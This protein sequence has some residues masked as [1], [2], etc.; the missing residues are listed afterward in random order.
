MEGA[1]YAS[2]GWP[3]AKSVID[4]HAAH[5][6]IGCLNQPNDHEEALHLAIMT[7]FVTAAALSLSGGI[8]VYWASG[9]LMVA[10]EGWQQAVQTVRGKGLPVED[11]INLFW[12]QEDPG[13]VGAVTEGARAFLGMEIEFSPALLPPA[14]IADRLFGVMRYLLVHGAVLKD[15]D[16]IGQSETEAIRVRF[17]ERGRQFEGSVI[18][19]T[20][21]QSLPKTTPL[22][23][24]GGAPFGKMSKDRSTFGKRGRS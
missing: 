10:P 24:L 9:Q 19:L 5:L 3:E 12:V 15:G 7:T 13:K 8:G 23:G 6:I 2:I 22:P 17:K 4:N 11:W 1:A 16:T 18:E 20:F 21:E 14:D